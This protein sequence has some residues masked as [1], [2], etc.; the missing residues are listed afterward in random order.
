[1]HLLYVVPSDLAAWMR[2]VSRVR[3]NFPGLETEEELSDY[4]NT[5]LKFISK[6]QAICVKEDGEIMTSK[7][8][9]TIL[10]SSAFNSSG[11]DFFSSLFSM[12]TPP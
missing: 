3:L 11:M 2:L 6:R 4:R 7:P 5:V 9:D 12:V 1:M 10:S 8:P